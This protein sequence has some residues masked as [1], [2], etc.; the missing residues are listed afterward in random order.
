MMPGL[1]SA[2]SSDSSDVIVQLYRAFY[3]NV[4]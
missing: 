2:V 1:V 3:M 4:I